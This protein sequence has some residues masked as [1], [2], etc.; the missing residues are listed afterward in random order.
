M[1]NYEGLFLHDRVEDLTIVL[2]TNQK[3]YNV[4]ELVET[5][6]AVPLGK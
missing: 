4:H 1:G 6:H 3:H 5:I 2:L